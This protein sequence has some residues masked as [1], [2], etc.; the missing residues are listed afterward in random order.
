MNTA[1]PTSQRRGERR[2][3]WRTFALLTLAGTAWMLATP[4]M[5]GPDEVFQARRL[6]R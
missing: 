2:T 4:L 1:E 6:R 3:W 5:T